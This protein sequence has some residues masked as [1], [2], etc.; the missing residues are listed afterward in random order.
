MLIRIGF[1]QK[2]RMLKTRLLLK[3]RL[4]FD[5]FTIKDEQCSNFEHSPLSME[6]DEDQ[7]S[8][9]VYIGISK[10]IPYLVSLNTLVLES[11]KISWELI[12]YFSMKIKNSDHR[13]TLCIH[14]R[15]FQGCQSWIFLL[16]IKTNT[17]FGLSKLNTLVLESIKTFHRF[18][19]TS[20]VAHLITLC[21]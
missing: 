3:I 16:Y 5:Q 14:F 8:V 17:V 1:T 20:S 2:F 11:I 10:Q 7:L 19:S 4:F 9:K 12:F 6:S 13:G 18:I 15:F 21:Q